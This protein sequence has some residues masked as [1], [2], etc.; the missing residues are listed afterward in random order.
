MEKVNMYLSTFFVLS[1]GLFVLTIGFKLTH[2][3]N[4]VDHLLSPGAAEILDGDP[5]AY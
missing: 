1:F 5:E 4:P 3:P 2:L